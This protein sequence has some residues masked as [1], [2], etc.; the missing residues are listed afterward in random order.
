MLHVGVCASLFPGC[1]LIW[2]SAAWFCR[3]L[4]ASEAWSRPR[5]HFCR[6]CIPDGL[7][8]AHFLRPLHPVPHAYSMPPGARQ[9]CGPG[10]ALFGHSTNYIPIRVSESVAAS[11]SE[12]LSYA[13]TPADAKR[14]CSEST[15]R[16]HSLRIPVPGPS[17]AAGRA[18]RRHLWHPHHR[19]SFYRRR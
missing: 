9:L 3:T 5:K 12:M 18:L 11:A 17:M 14:A 6:T 13:E 16:W 15:H 2:G 1:A 4:F 19:S 10:F 8:P 7:H